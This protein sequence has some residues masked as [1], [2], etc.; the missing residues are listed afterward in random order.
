MQRPPYPRALTCTFTGHRPD[1]LPWHG[2]E[3]D[4]RCL[5]LKEKLY[6]TVESVYAGGVRH[7]IC[8]MARGCDFYF[9]EAVIRLR[10]EYPAVS[11][12][13]AIPCAAQSQGW[14]AAERRRYDRLVA[15]CDEFNILYPEYFRGCM[16]ARNR[17]MVERSS[18]LIAIF[19]GSNGGTAYTVRYAA[20]SGLEVVTI[21][22]KW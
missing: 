14:T 12:E 19:N 9:A 21:D 11:L 7:F 22:P 2:K 16:L 6:D 18:V 20:K 13:A 5:A 1:K 8:G 3:E 17:Y 15:Q 4:P 10:L